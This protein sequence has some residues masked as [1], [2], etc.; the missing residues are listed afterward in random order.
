MIASNNSPAVGGGSR[1]AA[2]H[3]V[4]AWCTALTGRVIGPPG[5]GV[6]RSRGTRVL[7][8]PLRPARAVVARRADLVREVS[9][10]ASAVV[11]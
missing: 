2:A 5:V 1:Q 9:R 3:T 8:R 6:K 4:H 11:P 10:V 7:V